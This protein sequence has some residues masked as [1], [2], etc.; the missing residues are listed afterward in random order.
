MEDE[1][2]VPG[3]SNERMTLWV[4][5]ELARRLKD[6]RDRLSQ[7]FGAKL[8]VNSTVQHLLARAL[9]ENPQPNI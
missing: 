3:K 2:A 4:K 5:P 9:G 7:E 1:K 8:S 6:E